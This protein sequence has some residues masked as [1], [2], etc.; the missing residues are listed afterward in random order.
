MI[1]SISEEWMYCDFCSKLIGKLGDRN[2]KEYLFASTCS[3]CGKNMCD[4][5]RILLPF[6]PRPTFY[7]CLDHLTKDTQKYITK[8]TVAKEL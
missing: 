3:M 2:L 8:F 5:C 7:L 1:K 4:K 6:D